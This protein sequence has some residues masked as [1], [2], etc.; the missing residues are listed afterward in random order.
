MLMQVAWPCVSQVRPKF[1]VHFC[2]THTD[3]TYKSFVYTSARVT[4]VHTWRVIL[5]D[6]RG[7]VLL[8]DTCG[9]VILGDTRGRVI[10]GDTRGRVLLGETCREVNLVHPYL[11]T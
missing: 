5:G 10:L 8:G 4:L 3:V 11:L 6:T 7:R 1:K 9:R 2:P